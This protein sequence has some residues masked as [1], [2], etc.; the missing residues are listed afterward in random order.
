LALPAGKLVDE[1]VRVLVHR[2]RG[3]RRRDGGLVGG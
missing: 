3:Q 2:R 1:P